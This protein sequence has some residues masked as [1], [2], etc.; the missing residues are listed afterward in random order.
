M[1]GIRTL[2]QFTQEVWRERALQVREQYRQAI[3][4]IYRAMPN[5]RPGQFGSCVLVEIAGER[6]IVTASHVLDETVGGHFLGVPPRPTPMNLTFDATVEIDGRRSDDHVDVAVARLDPAIAAATDEMPFVPMNDQL[7]SPPPASSR[8]FLVLGY[9]A[10]RNRAPLPGRDTMTPE[11]WTYMGIGAAV[12]DA[13]ARLSGGSE[14]F[15]IDYPKYG[16][17]PTGEKVPNADPAGASGGAVFD[18]GPVGDINL[19]G[20]PISFRPRLAGILIECRKKV[21]IATHIDTVHAIARQ[22]RV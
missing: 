1:T 17:R 6:C 10:S 22:D 15:G 4:P 13:E 3:R 18:L 21:L 14:N 20:G 2:A 7:A 9:R 19:L 5:R 8:M 16:F 11:I 12:P